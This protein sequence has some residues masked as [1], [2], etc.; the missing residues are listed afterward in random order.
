MSTVSA[1]VEYLTPDEVA[2]RWKCGRRLVYG[3]V[4]S[5]ELR[6]LRLGSG[7]RARIRIRADVLDEFARQSESPARAPRTGLEPAVEPQAHTG[8]KGEKP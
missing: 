7:P 8:A 6:H 2:E 5:G 3:L 4:A 1:P